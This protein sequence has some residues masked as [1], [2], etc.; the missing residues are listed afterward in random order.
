MRILSLV[1]GMLLSGHLHAGAAEVVSATAERQSNDTYRFSVTLRHADTGWEHYANR[2][3][4]LG[5]DD[6]VLGSR[7]LHHPHV[8]EQP[9][10]RSLSGVKIP[11]HLKQVW[12]RAADSVHGEAEQR[13]PVQLR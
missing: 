3:D 12:I 10:T 11:G 7:I 8:N 13:Y 9:F 2:W 4:V 5:P 6:E 1:A